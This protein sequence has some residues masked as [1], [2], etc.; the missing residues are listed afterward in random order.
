MNKEVLKMRKSLTENGILTEENKN[1]NPSMGNN[2]EQNHHPETNEEE[3][4]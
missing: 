3:K 4:K 2:E 1:R